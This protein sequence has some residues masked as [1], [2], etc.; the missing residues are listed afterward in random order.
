MDSHIPYD[1]DSAGRCSPD[2]LSLSCEPLSGGP[3]PSTGT[4]PILLF[5]DLL[6]C[7]PASSLQFGDANNTRSEETGSSTGHRVVVKDSSSDVGLGTR[8]LSS[9]RGSSGGQSATR[10]GTELG[11]VLA[12][13]EL[14]SSR[15]ADDGG[16]GEDLSLFFSSPSRS[17]CCCCCRCSP[18]TSS[19]SRSFG[20]PS[21]ASFLPASG[22]HG[23]RRIC[24]GSRGASSAAISKPHPIAAAKE[25]KQDFALETFDP[26]TGLSSSNSITL[27]DCVGRLRFPLALDR[28]HDHGCD[29]DDI[30]SH[31]RDTHS[32]SAPT[33]SSAEADLSI[34][35]P[36]RGRTMYRGLPPPYFP[37]EPSSS[38][39]SP[40]SPSLPHH[41]SWLR[42]V[43]ISLCI[44]QECFRA[45]F[46]AFKLVGYTKPTLPIHSSRAGMQKLLVGANVGGTSFKQLSELMDKTS[47]D[48][49]LVV[50]LDVG[51]AEFMPLKRESFLFHHSAM[52][53]PPLIRRLTVNG[54]ESRDYL[55]QHARLSIKSTDGF[56]V[57]AVS[58]SEIR[59]GSGGED[60]AGRSEGGTSQIR[61]EWQFEYT[62]EDKR[63]A[64]GTKAGGG[65][66]NLTP[67]RFSC[68]PGLLH[69]R[70]GRKVTV[71]N[72]W[73]KSIQPKLVAGKVEIPTTTSPTK[74]RPHDLT[75]TASPPTS[76]KSPLRFPTT[77]KLWGK[78]AKPSPY[79]FDKGSDGSEECL[80]PSE[81]PCS[82]RRRSR[83]GSACLSRISHEAELPPPRRGGDRGQIA[84]AFTNWD[85]WSPFGGTE[86][87]RGR[88]KSQNTGRGAT[89]EDENERVSSRSQGGHSTARFVYSR[90][91][92]TAR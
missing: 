32:A 34:N 70:Q 45:V 16:R 71:L 8:E 75:E 19:R 28:D 74:H 77:G 56:Q 6:G 20:R 26:R 12:S 49:D 59:R 62:V 65:E 58:G 82:R 33:L 41:L 72:V 4:I 2:S 29:D 78:R 92:R 47:T 53:T 36:P 14:S 81:D 50:N 35:F 1:V 68:S 21:R 10:G 30:P 76:P 64:D 85:A 61:L 57:Y 11:L 42:N 37:I 44:D 91:P 46:P 60:R 80:I 43:T 31:Q 88:S 38:S 69:S 25:H 83:P 67:L 3:F 24:S 89:S 51:M 17:H 40:S 79:Q 87:S 52:D 13:S 7:D 15:S 27:C 48:P 90:R 18:S 63:K 55:S 73:K 54:D 5:D 84:D 39:S 23:A 22:G 86:R 66:K 9:V